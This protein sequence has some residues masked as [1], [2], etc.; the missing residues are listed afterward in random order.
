MSHSPHR[1]LPVLHACILDCYLMSSYQPQSSTLEFFWAK[2][3]K[4][5]SK[6]KQWHWSLILQHELI[7]EAMIKHLW[8]ARLWASKGN[9]VVKDR[10]GYCLNG[11]IFPLHWLSRCPVSSHTHSH[12]LDVPF[13]GTSPGTR[14]EEKR[15]M[16]YISLHWISTNKLHFLCSL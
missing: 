13:W 9:I 8:H 15:R 6:E 3:K 16:L 10:F 7:L 5:P 4:N 1:F 2:R 11:A 12:R 14:C